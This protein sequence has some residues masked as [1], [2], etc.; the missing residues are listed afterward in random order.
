[1]WPV[2]AD[3]ERGQ[4]NPLKALGLAGS[5]DVKRLAKAEEIEMRIVVA[6]ARRDLDELDAAVVTL[7]CKERSNESEDWA[8]RLR[9]AYADVMV[10][11]FVQVI[12]MTQ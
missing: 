3:C 2:V 10:I 4:D 11:Q 6:R 1:M 9:H 12:L 8:V 5:P 7:I